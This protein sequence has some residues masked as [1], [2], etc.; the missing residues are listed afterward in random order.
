MIGCPIIFSVTKRK[1]QELLLCEK[2]RQISRGV[3]DMTSICCDLTVKG[4]EKL[5]EEFVVMHQRLAGNYL[6]SST[7]V[8][9]GADCRGMSERAL[10]M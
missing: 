8:D 5:P 9:G 10:R 3:R 6:D 4:F 7:L 1:N 2:T